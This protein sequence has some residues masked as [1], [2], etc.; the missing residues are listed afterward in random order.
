VIGRGL[1]IPGVV[2]ASLDRLGPACCLSQALAV[3]KQGVFLGLAWRTCSRRRTCGD[4]P[5]ASTPAAPAAPPHQAD[6]RGGVGEDAHYPAA[7]LDFF[8]HPLQQVGAPDLAPVVLGEV[9][10]GKHVLFGL[11]HQCSG[12]G[13]ALRQR[14]GQII[15]AR[16]VLRRCFLGEHAA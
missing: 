2:A 15:P 16:L 12:L 8:I 14:G 3:F 7:A 6:D 1:C 10:E 9:A 4:L 5:T 13:E 11:V